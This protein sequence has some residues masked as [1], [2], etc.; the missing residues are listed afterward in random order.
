MEILC[1]FRTEDT[2]TPHP[3][4]ERIESF[5]GQHR[6]PVRPGTETEM[7]TRKCLCCSLL[8]PSP[9]ARRPLLLGHIIPLYPQPLSPSLRARSKLS[10]KWSQNSLSL[11]IALAKCSS[12]LRVEFCSFTIEHKTPELQITSIQ[13]F[14][15]FYNIRD[16]PEFLLHSIYFQ[17]L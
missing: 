7:E 15:K 12:T 6:K 3:N 2:R 8:Q 5:Q 16:I 13:H 14:L 10:K 4:L 11:F 1:E 9:A 17:V